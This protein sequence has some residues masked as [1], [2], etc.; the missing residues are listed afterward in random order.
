MPN[1][2]RF[3][4]PGPESWGELST[5]DDGAFDGLACGAAVGLTAPSP[6][7]GKDGDS[8][9]GARPCMG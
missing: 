1:T 2:G 8:F 6:E 3:L 9:G 5:A 4:V 7:L